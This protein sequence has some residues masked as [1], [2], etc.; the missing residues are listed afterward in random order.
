[1]N[2]KLTYSHNQIYENKGVYGDKEKFIGGTSNRLEKMIKIVKNLKHAPENILDVGCGTGYFAHLTKSMYPNAKVYG[3]DISNTALSIGRRKYK[4][5]IF[6]KADAEVEL[7]FNGNTFDLV[8]SG[9]HIEHI[10]DVDQNLLEI[11]RVTK[12]G[13]ILLVTTPN[14]ASWMNRIF[15]LFGKQPWYLD[16]SLRKT[17]PVFSIGNYTFPK[18]LSSPPP[19]HLRLYTLDMLKKLLRAYGFKTVDVQGRMML[20]KILIKQI[21]KLFS[22]IPP[23]AFGLIVKTEKVKNI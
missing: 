9:E 21:D 18:N 4:D 22:N 11:N 2:K 15:L 16:P 5:I 17:L 7:P 6:V 13:G 23:L 14:L 10:R 8:I 1:M 20:Q 3:I 12:K 19:G